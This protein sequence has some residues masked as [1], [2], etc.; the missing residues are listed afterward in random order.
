MNPFTPIVISDKGKNSDGP[1]RVMRSLALV[2]LGLIFLAGIASAE[3]Y[4]PGPTKTDMMD[5]D[6]R[7]AKKNI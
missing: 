3:I 4:I 1:E 5:S 2:L 7:L 6:I